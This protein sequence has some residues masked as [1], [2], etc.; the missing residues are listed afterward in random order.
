MCE[1]ESARR[2]KPAPPQTGASGGGGRHRRNQSK[3]K[4]K[5]VCERI[6]KL[7]PPPGSSFGR[8]PSSSRKRF[9]RERQAG[10]KAAVAGRQSLPP[11]VQAE[12]AVV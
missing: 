5:Q 4:R 12:Q 3:C 9:Q 7:P 1:V 11:Q 8:L 10:R 2:E 6:Q